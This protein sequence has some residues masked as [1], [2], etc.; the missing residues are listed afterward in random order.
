MMSSDDSAIIKWFRSHHGVISRQEALRLGLTA[1]QIGVRLRIGAWEQV[2]RGVYRLAGSPP[3]ALADLRA[4][5]LAN[6]PG[7]VASHQSAAWLWGIADEPGSPSVT[8]AHSGRNGPVGSRASRSRIPA[9]VSVRMGIPCTEP[10]RTILDCA[11]RA[12]D[13]E[14]DDLIDRALARRVVRVAELAKAVTKNPTYRHHPGRT[15]LRARLERR[16]VTGGPAPSVLESRLARILAN[17]RLPAP[18]AEVA[19][20]PQRRYRLDF[21]YPAIRLA[22]EVD[23]R[24]A[25]FT[26]EQQRWDHRRSNEL[27]RAGWTVLHYN[28][29][30]VTFEPE[31]VGREIVATYE[32]LAAA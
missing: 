17:V 19:W 11:T 18:R 23:G 9:R 8:R 10:L 30:E 6:G 5:V 20:G 29:W 32:S 13:A 24:A 25:H 7:A 15:V 1:G 22:I 12:G 3:G 16:G 4:A 26:P 28:W 21:A 27:A 31:R 14:I 2:A